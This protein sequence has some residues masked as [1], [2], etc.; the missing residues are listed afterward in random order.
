MRYAC[1]MAAVAALTALLHA[2][3]GPIEWS[4]GRKLTIA[5]FQGPV[6][7]RA[8]LRS[9]PTGALSFLRI[10][11]SF[12]C[13]GKR[14]EGSARVLFYPAQSWWVG[15]DTRMWETAND[16]KSWLRASR[17]DLDMKNAIADANRELLNHEQ[18]HFDMAEIAARKIRRRIAEARDACA[19][20]SRSEDLNRF[21]GEVTRDFRQEQARYDQDTKH[22]TFLFNQ[23][24]WES[25]VRAALA[26]K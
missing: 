6:P 18:L 12:A 21:V 7:S 24:K 23:G 25:R 14:L 20:D 9:V 17:S 13:R 22:G 11:P 5:D 3:G 4:A 8:R 16:S 15:T 19:A 10:E 1:G 2:Q 26:A